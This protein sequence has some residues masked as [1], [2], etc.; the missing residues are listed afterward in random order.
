MLSSLL[1]KNFYQ[2]LPNGFVQDPLQLTSVFLIQENTQTFKYKCM[3]VIQV[4]NKLSN[5]SVLEWNSSTLRII[6]LFQRMMNLKFLDDE[7]MQ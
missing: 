2:V 4:E 5:K 3:K 6:G 1:H 7:S